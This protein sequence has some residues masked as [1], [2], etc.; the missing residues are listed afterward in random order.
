[1]EILDKK[2]ENGDHWISISDMMA[3]LMMIFLFIA[4]S[5]MM[6]VIKEKDR[7]KEIAVTYS[8]LQTDLYQDLYDE[9]KDDLDVW[10]AVIDK[11]TLSVRFEAPEVLFKQGRSDLQSSFTTILDDFF[12]R[13]VAILTSKKFA[14]DI[15][16]IRIEGHTSTE[17]QYNV[18]SDQAYI[19]NMEL[20]QDRTRSVLGY[21]LDLEAIKE[22][23]TWVKERLTANGLSSSKAIFDEE[24]EDK[25]KSRRVEFRIKTNAEQRIVKILD[26]E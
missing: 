6:N 24:V 17:W 10:N 21:V 5:Y 22:Q 7:I 25:I 1:M 26:T 16:E 12:P 19:L 13:F 4:I 3:G 9:F 11:Q 23:R 15:D 14:N 2:S 8:R 18:S 20:S